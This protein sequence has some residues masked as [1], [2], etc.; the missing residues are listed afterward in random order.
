MLEGEIAERF[1]SGKEPVRPV[2][3]SHGLAS[4]SRLYTGLA[5][6]LASHGFLVIS[7]NHQDGSCIYTETKAETSIEKH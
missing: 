7:L 1:R 3:F 5:R 4:S 6:D 2:I